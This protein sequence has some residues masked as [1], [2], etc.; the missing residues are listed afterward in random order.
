MSR[1]L[2]FSSSP[3]Q[4][5]QTTRADRLDAPARMQTFLNDIQVLAI[6]DKH[7]LSHVMTRV[8]RLAR[9]AR[10]RTIPR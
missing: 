2:P 5:S 9:H 3:D 1:L 10:Q 4:R 7:T 6:M 8:R